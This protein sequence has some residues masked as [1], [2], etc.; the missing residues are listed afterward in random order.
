MTNN[1]VSVNTQNID[2]KLFSSSVSS[3]S[4]FQAVSKSNRVPVYSNPRPLTLKTADMDKPYYAYSYDVDPL[5][6]DMFGLEILAGRNFSDSHSTDKTEAIILNEEA[7]RMFKLGTPHEALGKEFIQY[8][9][10]TTNV[11]VIGVLKN[12]LYEKFF[13]H[14]IQS[15]VLRYNPQTFRYVNLAYNSEKKEEVK[16]YLEDVWMGFDEVHAMS[17]MFFD[18]AQAEIDENMSGTVNLIAWACGYILIIA[19]FGLL[20]MSAYTAELRKK[21]VGLRKVLGSSIMS[22]VFLL[23]KDYLRLIFISSVIAL[24][25]GYLLSDGMMQ[26][27]AYKPTLNLLVLPGAFLMILIPS[28]IAIS[29]QTIKAAMT[30][31]V[32]TI[33]QE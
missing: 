17:S 20:G 24:P 3:S 33:R 13:E 9:K 31:P 25:L 11:K 28:L 12:F 19:L 16:A 5:F 21:E 32:E 18:D 1:I 4:L 27:F 7:L 10:D 14:P 22:A 6:I 26:F 23:S 15:F 8:G 2:P 29:S 30:N